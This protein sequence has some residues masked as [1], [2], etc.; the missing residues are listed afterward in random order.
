[1]ASRSTFEPARS[2]TTAGAFQ[3]TANGRSAPQS[4]PKKLTLSH[5]TSPTVSSPKRAVPVERP[6][7]PE[8]ASYVPLPPLTFQTRAPLDR[9][10]VVDIEFE[11]LLVCPGPLP[12]LHL[13]TNDCR[14]R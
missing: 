10:D 9:K 13:L 8:P 2:T 11:Q 4:P 7:K 5:T 3:R 6:R 14:T 1:M 12:H